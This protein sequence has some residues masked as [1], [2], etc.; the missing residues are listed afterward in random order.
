MKYRA[1]FAAL[2]TATLLSSA[3]TLA[4]SQDFDVMEASISDIHEAYRAGEVSVTKLVET[5]LQRIEEIDGGSISL[6]SLITVSPSALEVAAQLDESEAGGP[7]YGI[8]IILKDNYDTKDMPT[9]GG[10][11]SLKDSTP[12]ADATIVEKMR[13]A[14]AIILAKGNLDEWA[15]GGSPGGGYS[16]AGGQTLNPYNLNRGPAGLQRRPSCR[17]RR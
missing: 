11:L 13:D 6:N 16:S 5:Y 7:L 12:P 9:T 15:H 17:G 4:Q 1:K 3:P 8:P 14:G 2:M 10:S